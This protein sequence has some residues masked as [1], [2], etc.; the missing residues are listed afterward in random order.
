MKAAYAGNPEP[1][2]DYRIV[3]EA[4]GGRVLKHSGF[5]RR[6]FDFTFYTWTSQDHATT[7]SYIQSVA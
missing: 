3:E 2:P 4:G 5:K 7:T 1:E 6:V